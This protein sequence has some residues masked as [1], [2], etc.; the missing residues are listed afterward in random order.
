MR[1]I[2]RLLVALGLSWS[3]HDIPKWLTSGEILD[4]SEKPSVGI[5]TFY[6]GPEMT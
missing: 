4:F 3:I 1:N 5:E 2:G 6:I